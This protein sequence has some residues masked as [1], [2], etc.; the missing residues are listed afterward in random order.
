MKQFQM[1]S[2]T[3]TGRDH[4]KPLAWKNGQDAVC[5][6]DLLEQS[7]IAVAVVSDGCGSGAH[8]E[9][10]A[11]LA[12][13]FV[14]QRILFYLPRYLVGAAK[15]ADPAEF[16]YFEDIRLDL[17][18]WLRTIAYGID[19]N[20]SKAVKDYCLFTLMGFVVTPKHSF[21]FSVGDGVY[22]VNGKVTRIGP[23]NS[24]ETE[25]APPYVSYGLFREGRHD[26]DPALCRFQ[27]N[28][29]VPTSE[30]DS[31]LVGTDGVFDLIDSAGKSMPSLKGPKGEPVKLGPLSQFW[32]DGSYFQ[33]GENLNADAI[34]RKLAL[35]N[36]STAEPDWA[37]WREERIY[38][39][40]G[41]LPDDTTIAVI[42]R[43]EPPK[44]EAKA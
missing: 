18:A 28:A 34:R 5:T 8:S 11:K 6:L 27:V 40:P 14:A 16:P 24:G 41:L 17:L 9:V 12:S 10:G 44:L 43:A 30:V 13:R 22:A 7:G 29:A 19:H 4:L 25:N 2:G 31:I 1:A 20:L 36:N 23:F 38:R 3:V 21:V 39:K 35:A 33:D 32:E 37:N 26:A 42:R 15:D